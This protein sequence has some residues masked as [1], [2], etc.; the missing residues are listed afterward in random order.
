APRAAAGAPEVELPA[1]AA[2]PG[3]EARIRLVGIGGT[4]VVTVNQV[5]GMA[6]LLDRRHAGG[7]GPTRPSPKGRARAGR[8]PVSHAAVR[9]GAVVPAGEADLLLGFDLLGAAASGSLR[10]ARPGRTVAVVATALAPT[11]E[12]VVDARAGAPDPAAARAAI[13][14]VTRAADNVY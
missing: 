2:A 5:L 11:G 3:P 6:A 8:P 4:G 14:A 7:A 13:D 9:A 12:M 1:P 10:V